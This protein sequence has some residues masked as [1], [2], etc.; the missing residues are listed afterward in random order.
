MNYWSVNF[1]D[2]ITQEQAQAILQLDRA[3]GFITDPRII[4]RAG[5]PNEVCE[6]TGRWSGRPADLRPANC[7]SGFDV[8]LFRT[9]YI[10]QAYQNTA[11]LDFVFSYDFDLFGSEWTA[12]AL[13]T[14]TS[15]YDMEVLGRPVD[16]VGS[17]NTATFGVPNPEWRGNLQLD[18]SR[19][20]HMA[21]ATYRYTSKLTLD[22]VNANNLLTEQTAFDTV[23]LLYSYSLA[24][25][26]GDVTF[27]V[28]NLLDAEDPLRHG[29]QTTS[30][31]SIYEVRG[32]VYRLGMSWGF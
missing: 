8:Q 23:D 16:G 12:K 10:N 18:W 19:G 2:I 11:G 5:A 29:A 6:V 31:S 15:K 1:K 7:M 9:T 13:G 17:Y 25:G 20:N 32:R 14:W 4:L 22:S 27:S 30:T 21:R 24:E 3:D 28:A 26:K